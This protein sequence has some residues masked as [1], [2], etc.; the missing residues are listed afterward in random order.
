MTIGLLIAISFLVQQ[1]TD[2]VK[3]LRAFLKANKGKVSKRGAARA[4]GVSSPTM[5][6]WISGRKTPAPPNRRAL[7]IWTGG[8]V[9]ESDWISRR[10][11]E[12]A[13]KACRVAPLEAE[14]GAA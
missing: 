10:E 2:G 6:D 8:Q 5:L 13:E 1:L 3:K 4:V 12:S 11:R 14:K 7:E 9:R